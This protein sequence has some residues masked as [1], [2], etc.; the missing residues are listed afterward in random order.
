MLS[1]GFGILGQT[2]FCSSQTIGYFMKHLVFI[3]LINGIVSF[4]HGDREISIEGLTT[5][6]Y[7]NNLCGPRTFAASNSK[8]DVDK[9]TAENLLLFIGKPSDYTSDYRQE[10]YDYYISLNGEDQ[11]IKQ[12]ATIVLGGGY[13]ESEIDTNKEAIK[14]Q[15]D[16]MLRSYVRNYIVP[17][18]WNFCA[19]AIELKPFITKYGCNGLAGIDIDYS[20]ADNFCEDPYVY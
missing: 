15:V 12:A 10:L 16:E 20:K 11:I 5:E 17:I 13:N 2:L 4:A 19:T 9:V 14:A 7:Y 18:Q 8:E 3:L 6:D 1:H